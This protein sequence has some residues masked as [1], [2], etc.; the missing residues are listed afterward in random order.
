MI[1]WLAILAALSTLA[2][3]ISAARPWGGNSTYLGWW[4]YAGLLLLMAWAT[5][6]YLGILLL[7]G[8]DLPVKAGKGILLMGSLIIAGCGLAAYVDAF[9]LHPDPQGGLAFMAV[10]LYQLIFTGLL[11][12]LLWLARKSR[13][14]EV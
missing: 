3:M 14:K 10:P 11:A 9:W 1:R 8:R 13:E 6:P 5:L 7:A 4:G 2:L 12:G